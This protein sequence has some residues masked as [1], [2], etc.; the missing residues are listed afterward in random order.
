[1]FVAEVQRGDPFANG[2][3]FLP[4]VARKRSAPLTLALTH[5]FVKTM[6][7]GTKSDRTGLCDL[8]V[9]VI[10]D[11]RSLAESDEFKEGTDPSR[12]VERMIHNFAQRFVQLCHEESWSRKLAGVEA[13]KVFVT[14][15]DISRKFIIDMEVEVIRALLF[16]L[17]DAPKEAPTTA[18]NVSDLLRDLIRFCHSE[19]DG[20]QK[21]LKLTETLVLELTSPS[22]LSRSAA[23]QGL[24]LLAECTGQSLYDV[25]GVVAKNRLLDPAAGPI[26]S[27][28]LRAL[29]F[30]MQVGNLD[31]VAFMTELDP[32]LLDSTDEFVRLLQEV[33]ALADA[34]DPNMGK[35]S[36]HKQDW[37]LKTLRVACLRVLKAA[38]A[39]P[40]FMSKANLSPLRTK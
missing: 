3:S 9:T 38:I 33:L 22:A 16:C 4:D 25:M 12:A 13:L 1:M 5:C 39:A 15:L 2:T 11:F 7:A 35:P 40:D 32:P 36:T 14:K 17:R 24:K 30:P 10:G 18:E 8:I 20:K 28:P 27:K 29:P 34:E 23:Q 37:W 19:E 6:G 26:F 31:A 21:Q